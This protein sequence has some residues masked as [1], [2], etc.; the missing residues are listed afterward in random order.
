MRVIYDRDKEQ[1]IKHFE[2]AAFLND[3][4]QECGGNSNEKKHNSVAAKYNIT[5]N[6][7]IL[8]I[9]CCMHGQ[10]DRNFQKKSCS[11]PYHI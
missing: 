1:K 8:V 6:F 10:K 2:F 7:S 9:S 5:L 11:I 3:K 4:L